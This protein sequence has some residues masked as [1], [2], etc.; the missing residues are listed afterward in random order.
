LAKTGKE[1]D[2]WQELPRQLDAQ[3]LEIKNSTIQ[4]ATF[5]TADLGHALPDTSRGDAAKTLQ[6]P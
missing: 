4:D 6:E 5:F 1:K 2:L 3:V